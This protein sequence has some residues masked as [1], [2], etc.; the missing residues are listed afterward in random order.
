MGFTGFKRYRVVFLG[1]LMW[2]KHQYKRELRSKFQNST[3]RVLFHF[4]H[5]NP[6]ISS[7]ETSNH[8]K[9]EEKHLILIGGF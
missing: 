6:V 3:M 5:L 8:S 2:H 7:I 4:S 1:G 9:D